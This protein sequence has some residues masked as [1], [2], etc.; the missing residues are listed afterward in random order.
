[1]KKL[2]YFIGITILFF[3]ITG[4]AQN[5]FNAGYFVNEDNL[6]INCLLRNENWRNNPTEFEYKLAIDSEVLTADIRNTY[7]FGINDG[8]KYRRF[9]VNIDRSSGNANKLSKN[10]DPEFEE[11]TLFLKSLVE[12]DA[13]LY[14]FVDKDITIY[15]YST[16]QNKIK[17]L[18]RKKFILNNVVAIN[19]NYKIQL[20]N[21]LICSNIDKG[22]INKAYEKRIE[23]NKN[24][25]ARF[26]LK[27]NNCVN[28]AN[29]ISHIQ[30]HDKLFRFNLRTGF[31]SS[32]LSLK[33]SFNPNMNTD[34]NSIKGFKLGMESELVIPYT[35]NNWS[36][37]IEPLFHYRKIETSLGNQ[38][39]V[40]DFKSLE[41]PIGIRRYFD[42]RDILSL[43]I[44]ASYGIDIS[45]DKNVIFENDID[46]DIATANYM[47]LGVGFSIARKYSFEA[48]YELDHDLLKNHIYWGSDYSSLS[49]IVGYTIF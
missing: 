8:I 5:V 23:Y 4:T 45:L 30:N 46:L 40:V 42:L 12:G 33:N 1:M 35:Q 11:E 48:R 31:T 34:F 25:L 15:F 37:V 41:I 28:P 47:A 44:N 3:S 19:N 17:Q 22:N 18:I 27:Y 43:Y 29:T 39:K 13:D 10:K 14:Q 49:F 21:D 16:E 38:S 6:K 32:S 2:K 26:F 36:I 24:D 20:S 7:E 9:Q